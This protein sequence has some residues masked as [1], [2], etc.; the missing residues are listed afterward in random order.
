M[1]SIKVRTPPTVLGFAGFNLFE[2][3]IVP[4]AVISSL[5]LLIN[6]NAKI[7]VDDAD[8]IR[9]DKD[10]IDILAGYIVHLAMMKSGAAELAQ[11]EDLKSAFL[12]MA[13]NHNARMALHG[14]TYE[15]LTGTTKK[16]EAENQ[17]VVRTNG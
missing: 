1:D 6:A 12:K 7:P 11:T 8:F 4:S 2:T 16:E 10:Y 17:R 14:I 3:D 15:T 5:N 13:L 9:I